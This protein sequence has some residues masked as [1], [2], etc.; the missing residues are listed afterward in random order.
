MYSIRDILN[1]LEDI[2]RESYAT[3]YVTENA[4]KQIELT[5]NMLKSFPT[6]EVNNNIINHVLDLSNCLSNPIHLTSISDLYINIKNL[7]DM[8]IVSRWIDADNTFIDLSED[9]IANEDKHLELT[10]LI[11]LITNVIIPVLLHFYLDNGEQ[12]LDQFSEETDAFIDYYLSQI[13]QSFY[14]S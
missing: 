14:V 1:K 8:F 13:I 10:K 2:N 6:S 3:P 7:M 5:T 9:I 4:L 11:Y 12:F